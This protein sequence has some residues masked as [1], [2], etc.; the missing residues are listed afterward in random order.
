M[1]F[2]SEKF[3]PGFRTIDG[4]QLNKLVQEI[5][6][7]PSSGPTYY[8]N[9]TKGTD[10][11]NNTGVNPSQ[12]LATL[13]RA[14]AIESAALAGLGLS[15]VGRNA[16]VAFWGT[17]HR[18]ATLVWNLPATHLVGIAATQLRGKRAR[19]S[20]TG[21]TTGFNK[22]VQVTAQG[23]QFENFGTFYGFPNASAALVNW[24]D[25]AGRSSYQ[26]V[27]FLGFGD[28][29]TTTGSS[30]LTGSRAFVFNSSNGETTLQNCVFGDDTTTRNATNYTVEIAGAAARLSFI[31]SVFEALLG[32]SGG[33]SSHLLIGANGIDRY[34]DI[35]RCRFHAD[36]LGGPGGTA[37]AQA[38]NVSTS[39]GGAI[40]LD[41]SVA[42]NG[43]TAWQTTPTTNV[44]MN[45]TAP[46]A[47]GGKAITVA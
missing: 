23:C 36:V 19:I 8:V 28:T 5:N 1:G 40:I 18:T 39:A 13:D 12:P 32:S 42:A 11:L 16:I 9:E 44:Q 26:N 7:G 31:D 2:V 37:M 20:I 15:S 43:I 22:L 3:T 4:N 35:V 30:N 17:Q 10:N 45:M 41:Q 6:A 24:S 33:A 47:G 34:L 27:E 38:L 25:E 46:G 21:G 14:L 29:T